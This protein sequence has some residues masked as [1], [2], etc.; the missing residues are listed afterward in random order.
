MKANEIYEQLRQA[1]RDLDDADLTIDTDSITVTRFTW[2]DLDGIRFDTD[3]AVTIL[4]CDDTP[5]DCWKYIDND[6]Y[7]AILKALEDMGVEQSIDRQA[8][9]QRLTQATKLLGEAYRLLHGDK[10]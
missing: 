3:N 5:T 7:F 1:A 8:I 4:E 2:D 10:V 9:E 6:D